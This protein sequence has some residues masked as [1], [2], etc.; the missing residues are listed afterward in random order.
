MMCYQQHARN[1]SYET[2]PHQIIRAI[3]M[4]E[5][6]ITFRCWHAAWPAYSHHYKTCT[7]QHRLVKNLVE[8]V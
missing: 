3:A 7:Q 2:Q 1:L 8:R 4:Y 5:T 6:D